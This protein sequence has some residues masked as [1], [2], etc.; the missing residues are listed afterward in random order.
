MNMAH[1]KQK[2][3]ETITLLSY[4]GTYHC[5]HLNSELY[6]LMT[7]SFQGIIEK[8]RSQV[9]MEGCHAFLFIH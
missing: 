1:G 3:P 5:L 7:Q 9:I 8:N 6:Q 4:I 2:V